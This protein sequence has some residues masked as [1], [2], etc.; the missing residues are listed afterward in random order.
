MA[1]LHYLKSQAM[2][3]EILWKKVKQLKTT[4]L[5]TGQ[6][7]ILFHCTTPNVLVG[8]IST[9][10]QNKTQGLVQIL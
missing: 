2:F 6:E 8:L 4:T 7:Y 5:Q 3:R 10:T 1:Y 9:K